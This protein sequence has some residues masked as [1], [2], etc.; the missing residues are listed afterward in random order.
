MYVTVHRGTREIGGTCVEVGTSS[1]RLIIDVGIPLFGDSW[2]KLGG[3]GIQTRSAAQLASEG[4]LPKVPGLFLEGSPPD[5]ILLSHA[6]A[7]HSGLIQYTNPDI[8]VL[9]TKG[10]SK[11]MLAGSIF[12]R[13]PAVRND[14]LKTIEP[15]ITRKVGD[16][17]VTALSVDHSAFDS[18]AYLVEAGGKRILYSGDLRLHGRKPGM[19]SRLLQA[20]QQEPIDVL[21][22]E[23]THICSSQERGLTEDELETEIA[24]YMK[25][26]KGLV[27]AAFSPM[28]V[29]RLVT[30]YRAARRT[31]RTFVADPYSAFVM[32]LV[33]GQT[34][35]PR[36]VRH[37][38]ISVFYHRHFVDS[39]RRRQLQKIHNMFLGHQISR[40]ELL[41]KPSRHVIAFRQR[42]L[43]SDFDGAM[44]DGSLCLYSY[45][46]GYLDRPDGRQ[47]KESLERAGVELI[48]AH[49]SGH[50]FSGD[51]AG[52]VRAVNPRIVIPIHTFGAPRF[53]TFFDNV[54]LLEDGEC[55]EVP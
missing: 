27:L 41:E 38:G 7:D 25:R 52:F 30:F 53:Q 17:Q 48:H 11:L 13:Q 9:A 22:M 36:P 35:I 37:A 12:A 33:S 54:R 43:D 46:G 1:T 34:R 31:G 16:I 40:E 32:H 21:L 14:R 47:F 44:P 42:M 49:T 19:A 50:I 2:E 4:V 24:K 26:A 18:V 5:A 51:M 45:W 39:Y 8:P 3:K 10:T 6:H 23:G 15:G 55:L 29:D 28:N 20:A